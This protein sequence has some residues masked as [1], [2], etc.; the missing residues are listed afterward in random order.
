M[1]GFTLFILTATCFCVILLVLILWELSR[2]RKT[3]KILIDEYQNGQAAFEKLVLR[4][5]SDILVALKE[6]DQDI[7]RINRR[8]KSS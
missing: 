2:L 3:V 8:S 6:R 4:A 1:N 7:S 5:T